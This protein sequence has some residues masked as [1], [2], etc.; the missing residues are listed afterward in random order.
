MGIPGSAVSTDLFLY[1]KL[2]IFSDLYIK[3]LQN[4]SQFFILYW[5]RIYF[6][7]FLKISW[8]MKNFSYTRRPWRLK[9]FFHC[10]FGGYISSYWETIVLGYVY[11][12]GCRQHCCAWLRFLTLR[13]LVYVLGKC[14]G[15]NVLGV[16]TGLCPGQELSLSTALFFAW[17]IFF[18]L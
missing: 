10:A 7:L 8:F 4:Y 18:N 12:K 16:C 6:R 9:L 2:E 11:W 1:K 17:K 3:I 5:T 13:V 15:L 14:T